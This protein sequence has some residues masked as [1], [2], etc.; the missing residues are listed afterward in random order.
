M[1]PQIYHKEKELSA[2][3]VFLKPSR[4]FFIWAHLGLFWYLFISSLFA[5]MIYNT[6]WQSIVHFCSCMAG[7]ASGLVPTAGGSPSQANS[8]TT[9]WLVDAPWSSSERSWLGT[10]KE[11]QRWWYNWSIPTRGRS[12]ETLKVTFWVLWCRPIRSYKQNSRV[13]FDSSLELTNQISHMT[14]FSLSDWS[15]PV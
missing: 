12:K 5:S 1:E 13:E 15:I 11:K 3:L 4:F 14:K 7:F 2:E 8:M 6:I 10:L 9:Q